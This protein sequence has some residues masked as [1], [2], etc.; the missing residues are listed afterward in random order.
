MATA[1]AAAK[2]ALRGARLLAVV[3][4][5]CLVLAEMGLALLLEPLEQTAV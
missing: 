5:A 4:L 3:G 2:A 1:V